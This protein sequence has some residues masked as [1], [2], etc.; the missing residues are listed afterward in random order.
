[1][2]LI[3]ILLIILILTTLSLCIIVNIYMKRI[4]ELS[5]IVSTDFHRLVEKSV[6]LL[7]HWEEIAQ[8]TKRLEIKVEKYF[9][10]LDDTISHLCGKISNSNSWKKLRHAQIQTSELIK[11]VKPIA[12]GISAFWN[13][14]KR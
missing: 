12:K 13:E 4:Y 6:P 5:E 7:T 9:E 2:S 1:M 3:E 8:R 11:N 14:F 10:D